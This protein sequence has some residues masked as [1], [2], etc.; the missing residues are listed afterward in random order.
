MVRVLTFVITVLIALL[1][2]MIDLTAAGVGA[3]ITWLLAASVMWQY[4][5][6]AA[7]PG[8]PDA[9]DP[10]FLA[11][12][13]VFLTFGVRSIVLISG[14]LPLIEFSDPATLGYLGTTFNDLY[15]TGLAFSA[16]C[17]LGLIAGYRW[18]P[19]RSMDLQQLRLTLPPLGLGS[20]VMML[21]VFSLV[22]W[23]SRMYVF[24]NSVTPFEVDDASTMSSSLTL[25]TAL[26]V[27]CTSTLVVS[28]L[29]LR[30]NNS[31]V[32]KMLA[33]SFFVLEVAY[34][35]AKG[36]RT[37]LFG[38]GIILLSWIGLRRP[39]PV[40][41]SFLLPSLAILVLIGM[42]TVYR[43]VPESIMALDDRASYALD[44]VS[45]LGPVQ[46]FELGWTNVVVR[47]HGLDSVTSVL[48]LP[49]MEESS[50]GLPYVTSVVGPFIPRFLWESKPTFD[51]GQDFARHYFRVASSNNVSM[52][53][54]WFGDL[55]LQFPAP[56]VPLIGVIIGGVLRW[57]REKG[58]ESTEVP[59]FGSLLYLLIVPAVITIDTWLRLTLYQVTLRLIVAGAVVVVL[60][61]FAGIGRPANLV[62]SR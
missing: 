31:A 52:A 41:I 32:L 43:R 13:I 39:V 56:F 33:A 60:S 62:T 54:S 23:I 3:A 36:D 19:I 46:L 61:I 22:G 5:S 59:T 28:L 9:S 50:F 26:G 42:T 12:V 7:R 30:V 27:L 48:F 4:L 40:K 55:L 57:L 51:A 10:L 37:L 29:Y 11:G 58:L 44:R 1:T 45:E 17:W 14:T 38:A 16:V 18:A 49:A 47:Y 15:A 25:A 35:L 34:A 20:L 24:V 6:P 8:K 53:P 21:M 2:L